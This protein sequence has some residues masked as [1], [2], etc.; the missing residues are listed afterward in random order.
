MFLTEVRRTRRWWLWCRGAFARGL[1]M[2]A[3]LLGSA[4]FVSSGGREI[5]P[6]SEEGFNQE[7]WK[8]NHQIFVSFV[9][10]NPLFL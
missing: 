4:V 6:L 7:P 3:K 2:N 8:G 5:S 9:V 10:K 1:E